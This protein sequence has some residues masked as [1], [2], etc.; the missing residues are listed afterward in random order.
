MY[1]PYSYTKLAGAALR[2]TIGSAPTAAARPSRLSGVGRALGLQ[3]ALGS[4]AALIALAAALAPARVLAQGVRSD[5]T[6]YRPGIDV[7]DYHFRI[8]FPARPPIGA[9]NVTAEIALRRTAPVDTLVL[10]L[11]APMQVSD[12]SVN[13]APARFTRDSSTVR[14]ALPGGSGDS[15]AVALRYRGAPADGLVIRTDSAGRWTAFGDNYPDRARHWLATVDHPSDKAT[16]S[17]DV[18]APLGSRVVAN[19][20]LIEES[21]ETA[22]AGATPMVLTR[23]RTNRP[24]YTAVMVIGVAPF[25]VFELGASA[26]SLSEFPGCV[27][28]SVWVAPETRSTLP[29]AFARAGDIVAFFARLVAPFP[30]EKLA[31]V[32]S[33]TRYGGMENAGAIFYADGIFR[34]NAMSESLIAHETAHQWFGDAVTETEWPHVWLSEGFAT[35]FA[36]LWTEFSQGESAFVAEMKRSRDQLVKTPLTASEPI[37]RAAVPDLGKLLNSN[38]YGKAGYTLHMLR[39]E[40][41]DSAFFRGLRSYYLKYRHGNA[42]TADLQREL[43][44]SSGAKLDWFFE[45]WLYRP[46]FAELTVSWRYDEAR[47]AMSITVGQSERFQPYRLTMPIEITTAS[48]RVI[49]TSVHVNA[50]RVSTQPLTVPLDGPPRTVSFDPDASLLATISA[51]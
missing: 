45:Q 8:D 3:I 27:R 28:Q 49:R 34:R 1:L 14:I 4:C 2:M 36:A 40:I 26:C 42:L 6:T 33:A 25:A 46:G 7:L 9:I 10:D 11:L 23:W 29:G 37:V 51:K 32:M 43:E 38:V 22:P 20:D 17:W 48:G 39:G 15:L 18:R 5:R 12:V 50:S 19:G 35:Y 47:R 13:S 21:P 41:G 30:Y 24:I 31:H 16:V 44:A